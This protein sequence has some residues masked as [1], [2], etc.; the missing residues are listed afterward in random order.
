M[1][2]SYSAR[3]GGR[4]LCGRE[5][6]CRSLRAWF[7][8]VA[9]AIGSVAG[10]ACALDLP[11][12]DKVSVMMSLEQVRQIAGA[13]DELARVDPEFTLAT[14]TMT[15]APGMAAAGG[16]FDGR[17]VLIAQAYVFAGE[18]GA[19]ALASLREL[20]FK[21]VE[22]PDGT[23]RLYGKDDDTGRPLI[24]VID[25][26]PAT[27]TVYAYEQGEYERRSAQ[28]S[29]PQPPRTPGGGASPKSAGTGTDPDVRNAIAAGIA[30]LAGPTGPGT[31]PGQWKPIQKTATL[32]S[33]SSTTRHPDGSITTR[34]S[35][36]TVSVGV[37]PV[38]VANALLML[39]K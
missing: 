21:V 17:N 34:S 12:L 3:H 29:L 23:V 37:D 26:Q 22:N 9:I 33:S 31:M 18:T 8:F 13:P 1:K 35:K 28:K 2:E 24:V 11:T 38:G 19:Q 5:I 10:P 25:E 32:S 15:D 4:G 27:T 7:R 16:V 30:M 36:T 6:R 39:M 14:W 20:G